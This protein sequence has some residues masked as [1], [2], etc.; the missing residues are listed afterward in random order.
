MDPMSL[1]DPTIRRDPNS[2]APTATPRT[3]GLGAGTED[4]RLKEVSREFESIFVEQMLSAM[5]DTLDPESRLLHGGFAEEVFD[6]MLYR[7][8]SRIISKSGGF[9][10]AELVYDQL[11]GRAYQGELSPQ[12]P[13]DSVQ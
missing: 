7:E 12:G 9:G 8:Y 13:G 5:R 10:L 6:D 3:E 4:A 2:I 1:I 11:S